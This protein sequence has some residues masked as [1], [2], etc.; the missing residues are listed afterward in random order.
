MLL[1]FIP[2]L[3]IYPKETILDTGKCGTTVQSE[4][5][6]SGQHIQQMS[7]DSGLADIDF[8]FIIYRDYVRAVQ[9][10]SD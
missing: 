10:L 4:N 2:R 8:T 6:E 7:N 1:P 3:G 9:I 5:T